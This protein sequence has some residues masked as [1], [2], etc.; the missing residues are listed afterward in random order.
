MHGDGTAVHEALEFTLDIHAGPAPAPLTDSDH[1]PLRAEQ[2][3]DD[4]CLVRVFFPLN[5]VCR[6]VAL[7][8]VSPGDRRRC[9]VSRS[10]GLTDQ[11]SLPVQGEGAAQTRARCATGPEGDGHA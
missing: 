3:F 4:V 1:A 6:V 2:A 10:G 11:I 7:K 5:A 8:T 9:P